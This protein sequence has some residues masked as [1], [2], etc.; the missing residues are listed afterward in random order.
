MCCQ[1]QHENESHSLCAS[2]SVM[3]NQHGNCLLSLF[4][5]LQIFVVLMFST[6]CLVTGKLFSW[7]ILVVNLVRIALT[8]E[9]WLV[10]LMHKCRQTLPRSYCSS[11]YLWNII[12]HLC[13]LDKNIYVWRVREKAIYWQQ[14]C[15]VFWIF[16][17][18]FLYS[19]E[20]AG[21]QWLTSWQSE[22]YPSLGDF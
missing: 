18:L 12:C 16:F 5:R 11:L 13:W 2:D 9:Y 15:V 8:K 20:T 19:F 21:L 1:S 3:Q 17:F 6:L 22:W 10:D 7:L 4:G 14:V